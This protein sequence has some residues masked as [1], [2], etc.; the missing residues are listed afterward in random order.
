MK[1]DLSCCSP[2]HTAVLMSNIKLVKRFAT[3][4]SALGRSLDILNK[5][6]EVS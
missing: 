6:G 5:Y 2:I 4:L 3:V 1:P